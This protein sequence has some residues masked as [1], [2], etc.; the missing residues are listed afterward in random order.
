M[1][2]RAEEPLEQRHVKLF[3]GDFERL[4]RLLGGRLPPTTAIRLL[5]RQF[6]LRNEAKLEQSIQRMDLD[7]ELTD[8]TSGPS[9]AGSDLQQE[10]Q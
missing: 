5:V 2:R 1:V 7:V 8:E 3:A 9:I 6:I 4:D 10:P